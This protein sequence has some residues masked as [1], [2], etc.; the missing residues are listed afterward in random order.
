MSDSWHGIHSSIVAF[1]PVTFMSIFGTIDRNDI[2]KFSWEVLWLVAGGISLGLTMDLGGASWLIALVNWSWMGPILVIAS[3]ILVAYVMS[4]LISNTVAATML[5]PM[6]L[7]MGVTGAAGEGFD[8]VLAAI[9]ISIA[10]S[11][12]ML[13]PISTPPNAIAMS[14]GLVEG[15]TLMKIGLLVGITGCALTLLIGLVFWSHFL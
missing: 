9:S 13:L 12:S 15:R 1:I 7:T 8:S 11:F 10:V 4:N 3:L 14:S 5:V 2:K 6:A